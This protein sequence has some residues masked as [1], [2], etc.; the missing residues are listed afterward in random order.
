MQNLFH[1][2]KV[3][4]F[5]YLQYCCSAVTCIIRSSVRRNIVTDKFIYLLIPTCFIKR[6]IALCLRRILKKHAV[7][8]LLR[9]QP[10]LHLYLL[11]FSGPFTLG[12]KLKRTPPS[13]KAV[14]E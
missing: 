8:Y 7:F 1:L 6:T 2:P 11:E 12:K 5:A 4:A 13:K 10:S 14:S 3:Y 9:S